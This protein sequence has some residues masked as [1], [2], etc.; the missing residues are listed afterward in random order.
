[1]LKINFLMH[2]P[3]IA[4]TNFYYLR[5]MDLYNLLTAV[6]GDKERINILKG[7]LL[8]TARAK[9]TAISS[10]SLLPTSRAAAIVRGIETCRNERQGSKLIGLK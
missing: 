3:T 2:T 7:T 8:L 9:E 6:A 1:M 10:I 4:I 5:S